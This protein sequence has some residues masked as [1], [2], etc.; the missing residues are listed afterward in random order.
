ML[1]CCLRA[2]WSSRS[3]PHLHCSALPDTPF[4]G[5]MTL[6]VL[7]VTRDSS[8]SRNALSSA[9]AVLCSGSG[10]HVGGQDV[11][12][13]SVE[14]GAGAVVSH[15]GAWVGVAGGDLDV[16]QVDAGVEH[17]GDVGVAEHVLVHARQSDA[18]VVGEPAK[19]P[20]GGVAVQA[21][22]QGVQEQWPVNA[23]GNG[24]VHRAG[25]GWR[26]RNRTTLWPLPTTRSTRRPCSS[27]RSVM[28]A[29]LLYT[30]PSPRDRT[31]SR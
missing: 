19:S 12:G 30:S 2:R 11:V 13:V 15:G 17:R 25:D 5:G 14:G 7:G 29:C 18:G 22:A 8:H 24:A 28:S 26:Q 9:R 27:P 31:R 16:A 10:G 6:A 3:T 20:C 4:L 21:A 1:V 23:V